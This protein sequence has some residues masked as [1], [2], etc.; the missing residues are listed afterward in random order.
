VTDTYGL[1]HT[2]ISGT[3]GLTFMQQQL[4]NKHVRRIIF[5]A[6]FA[7]CLLMYGCYKFQIRAGTKPDL[8]DLEVDTTVGQDSSLRLKAAFEED[9]LMGVAV[10]TELLLGRDS[11]TLGMIADQFNSVTAE[12]CMKFT[13]IHPSPNRF[14]FRATDA[15]L[16]FAKSHQMTVIGHTLLWHR[17]SPKW[18]FQKGDRKATREEVLSELRAHM[19]GVLNHTYGQVFG[20]DVVNE[21]FTSDGSMRKTVW[22]DY[23]GTNYIDEAFKMAQTIDPDIQLYYN[24]FDMTTP[25]KRDAVVSLVKRLKAKGIRIDGI[26]MQG[27]W[28]LTYPTIVDI[29]RSIRAFAKTGVKVHVTELDIDILSNRQGHQGGGLNQEAYGDQLDPFRKGL[30]EEMHRRLAQRYQ[31]IFKLF[32]KHRDVIDRVTFWGATDRYTWKNNNP[33]RGRTNHPLLFDRQAKPKLAFHKVIQL[34]R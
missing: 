11:R 33:I 27:H 1:I 5:L 10:A 24:D 17:H 29:E 21:A 19:I 9:F 34:R 16:G 4:L 23:I 30:S 6:C 32:L 31:A 25:G 12:N 7:C 13:N 26:G 22:L 28:D 15:L 20:W 14:D 18:I 3:E 2:H 8:E